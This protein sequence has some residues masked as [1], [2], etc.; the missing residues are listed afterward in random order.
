MGEDLVRVYWEA[1]LASLPADSP[2]REKAYDP[3]SFGDSPEM[4]DGLG[5]LVLSGLKTATCSSMWEWEAGGEAL[6]ETGSIWI[7]LDG[8]GKPICITEI[9]EV[10][11]RKYKDVDAG[12][13]RAEGEGDPTL[14]YWRQAHRDYF[15]RVLPEI[16]K[17]FSEDMPLVC[18]RFRVIYK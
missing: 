13:A 10:T 11:I 7:V 12:F 3:D 1:F 6:P 9:P 18:E 5:A 14:A 8:G 16:G 15:T 4:A 2:Y 17:E